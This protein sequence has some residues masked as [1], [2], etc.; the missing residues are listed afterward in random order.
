MRLYLVGFMAVGKTRIGRRLAESLD[1]PFV[2]LDEVIENGAR[3]SVR[4]IFERFGEVYFRDLEHV[5][6]AATRRLES[7]VVATGGGSYTFE[8]NR[9]TIRSLGEALWI[10]VD[11][12]T[13]V[14]RLGA[15]GRAKRPLFGDEASA[16]RLFASR[17]T[18]YALADRHVEVPPGTPS[19]AVA[20]T[21]S[22]SIR[23]EPCAIS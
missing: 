8:R 21:I 22:R 11:F 7:V 23:E 2:D 12:D 13:I 20:D 14:S 19:E 15:E 6:L 17:R 4:R 3:M 16:R 5:A 10:D 1:V 18:S 9:R